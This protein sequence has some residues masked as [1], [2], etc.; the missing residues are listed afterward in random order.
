MKL[1]PGKILL[2]LTR[3]HSYTDVKRK[4]YLLLSM[5]LYSIIFQVLFVFVP[6]LNG[7]SFDL[8]II[9]LFVAD[10]RFLK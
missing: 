7:Y 3:L 8:N 10:E 6:I 1:L 5:N 2:I 4:K 9:A